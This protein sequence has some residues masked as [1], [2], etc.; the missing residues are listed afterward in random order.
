M[1]RQHKKQN[2]KKMKPNSNKTAKI[3][4]QLYIFANHLNNLNQ[5]NNKINTFNECKNSQNQD[6][7]HNIMNSTNFFKYLNNKKSLVLKTSI[8]NFFFLNQI[9]R[10]K[11]KRFKNTRLNNF[12]IRSSINIF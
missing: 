6:L 3:S 1:F 5:Y 11:F 2:L 4:T 10:K 7:D 12:G 9:S 8:L